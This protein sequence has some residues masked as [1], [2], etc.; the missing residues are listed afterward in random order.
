MPD[1]PEI[2][3]KI[4]NAPEHIGHALAQSGMSKESIRLA[5]TFSKVKQSAKDSI[6]GDDIDQVVLKTA[7]GQEINPDSEKITLSVGKFAVAETAG[8]VAAR[9]IGNLPYQAVS[10]VADL[11]GAAGTDIDNHKNAIALLAKNNVPGYVHEQKDIDGQPIEYWVDASA[12]GTNPDDG[13]V[14]VYN[15]LPSSPVYE[16]EQKFRN[17]NGRTIQALENSLT[18]KALE[19]VHEYSAQG[20]DYKTMLGDVIDNKM[21]GYYA[22]ANPPAPDTNMPQEAVAQAQPEQPQNKSTIVASR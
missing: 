8:H 22:A 9:A 12:A 2:V 5:E 16:S 10:M 21:T 17:N 20:N 11:I 4:I 7:K 6:G 15:A 13:K 18:N 1:V 14:K 19:Q 3:D